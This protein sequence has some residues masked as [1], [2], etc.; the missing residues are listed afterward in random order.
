MINGSLF[1][2]NSQYVINKKLFEK[3][4]KNNQK[5]LLESAKESEIWLKPRYEAWVNERVGKAVMEGGGSA[6]SLNKEQRL[7]IVENI[8][9]VWDKT[10]KKECGNELAIKN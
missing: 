9:A 8:Q 4:S 2:G 6:K 5:I 7:A 1:Y 3:L 10:F